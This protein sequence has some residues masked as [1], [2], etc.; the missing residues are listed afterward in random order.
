MPIGTY[1]ANCLENRQNQVSEQVAN[2]KHLNTY[3]DKSYKAAIRAF[4]F[5]IFAPKISRA[6]FSTR[7]IHKIQ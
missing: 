6:F 5:F 3:N 7:D 2:R 1:F 4:I